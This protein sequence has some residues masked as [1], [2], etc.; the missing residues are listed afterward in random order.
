MDLHTIIIGGIF[1]L[2]CLIPVLITNRNNKK[3]KSQFLQLLFKLAERNNCKISNFE[4]WNN[5]II[6]IGEDSNSVFVISKIDEVE[7]SLQINLA[8]IQKC[9]VM[10]SSRTVGEKGATMKVV[11][12]IELAFINRD[13]NKSDTLVPFYNADYDRLTLSGEIQLAEKWCKITNDTIAG[14]VK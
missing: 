14:K 4:Q 5:S 10:E 11:D 12:K 3:K 9:R 7:T 8:D 1:L 13:K 2:I 6:G